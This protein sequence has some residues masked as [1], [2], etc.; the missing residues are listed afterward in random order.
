[1]PLPLVVAQFTR[2]LQIEPR[3]TP[4]LPTWCSVAALAVIVADAQLV[5]QAPLL[6][7]PEPRLIHEYCLQYRAAATQAGFIAVHSLTQRDIGGPGASQTAAQF[8]IWFEEGNLRVDMRGEDGSGS[9]EWER[10]IVTDRTYT[11]IPAGEFEGVTAPQAEYSQS[12]GGVMGHFR[13]FHPRWIGM[14]VNHESVMECEPRARLVNP[15]AQSNVSIVRDEVDGHVAWKLTKRLKYSATGDSSAP[16]PGERACWFAP[17]AGWNLVRGEMRELDPKRSKVMTVQSKLRQ[18]G[19]D[20]VWFPEVVVRETRYDDRVTDRT[21]LTITEVEFGTPPAPQVFTV[22]GLG[23]PA[24]KRVADRTQGPIETVAISDGEQ[25]VPLSGPAV[26]PS[27]SPPQSMRA[28]W[29]LANAVVL[30]VVGVVIAVR[31]FR[32]R[33]L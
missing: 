22:A 5:A 17:H 12:E 27:P 31:A 23:L 1:M 30:A 20:G 3:A 28:W 24:G 33:K 32:R 15:A 16:I 14:G 7:P 2:W 19:T 6:N 18:Y 11:W 4:G 26:L 13:L 25:M 29:L 10:F 9:E 21:T 8:R